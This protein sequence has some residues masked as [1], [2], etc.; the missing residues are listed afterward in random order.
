MDK[1]ILRTSSFPQTVAWNNT[2]T[3]CAV[4]F[5]YDPAEDAKQMIMIKTDNLPKV[6]EMK[7]I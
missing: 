5:P 2:G 6:I 4:V 3:L 7:K 1:K